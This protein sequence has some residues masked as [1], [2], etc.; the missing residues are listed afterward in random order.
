MNS[1]L[2]IQDHLTDRKQ[3]VKVKGHYSTWGKLGQGVPQGSILDPL[4][5][6]I[7]INDIFYY[8]SN[9]AL[10]NFADDNT[11]SVT[12]TNTDELLLLLKTNTNND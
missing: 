1:L 3:V 9:G 12:A 4:L 11:L 2:L 5:F 7:S 10:C 8:L 6:N